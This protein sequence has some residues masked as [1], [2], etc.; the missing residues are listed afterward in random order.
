MEIKNLKPRERARN[1]KVFAEYWA[2]KGNEKSETQAF[3]NSL[4]RD[5][6]GVVKPE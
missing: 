2:G 1:A 4:L 6:F 3:W 5:I